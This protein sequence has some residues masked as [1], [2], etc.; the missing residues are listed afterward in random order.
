MTRTTSP[1]PPPPIATGPPTP[2]PRASVTSPVSSFAPGRKRTAPPLLGH[3][4]R[5]ATLAGA[6]GNE[7]GEPVAPL[8]YRGAQI[9]TGDL[10]DPNG[11]RYQAAPHPELSQ[12]SAAR[13]RSHS[14]HTASTDTSHAARY[15]AWRDNR[16]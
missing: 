8:V 7:R 10:S 6:A 13:R 4:S 14:R 5:N 11:A 1:M 12:R 16:G 15:V 2:R 9:R 3:V